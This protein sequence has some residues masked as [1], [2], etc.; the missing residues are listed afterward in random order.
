[1]I[2]LLDES[3]NHLYV[4][5]VDWLES[6]LTGVT[7]CTSIII[8]HDSGFLNNTITNILHLNCFKPRLYKGELS[9]A[10][11]KQV[12]VAKYSYTLEAAEDYMLKHLQPLSLT[13]STQEKSL[14]KMC[15]FTLQITLPSRVAVLG[16]T[17]LGSRRS[18]RHPNLVIG[19]VVQLAMMLYAAST[20][21][22]PRSSTCPG[23]TRPVMIWRSCARPFTEEKMVTMRGAAIIA[24]GRSQV[25][26]E[27]RLWGTF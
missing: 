11:A 24:E 23:V 14:L 6:F 7:R 17:V 8:P 22:R 10:F 19:Y 21:T 18:S 4:V 26:S 1:D 25:V 16:P 5:D 2:F 27:C 15:K 20:W 9:E 13:V 12:P 3:S